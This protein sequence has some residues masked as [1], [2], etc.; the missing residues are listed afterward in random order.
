MRRTDPDMVRLLD[1]PYRTPRLRRGD[2]AQCLY[3][4]K[5]VIVT[6]LSAGHIPWPMC[7]P[8]GRARPGLLVEEEVARALRCE[9]SLAVQHWW[10]AV[11]HES[12][13]ME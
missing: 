3:R 13:A 6:G 5:D 9:S 1:G 2:R 8:I 11:R 10:G 4:D 7:K 12:V